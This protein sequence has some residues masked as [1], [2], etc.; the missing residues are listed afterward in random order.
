[1]LPTF[2]G[3]SSL[4]TGQI[5]TTIIGFTVIY[6]ALAVV[7]IGLMVRTIRRGPYAHHEDPDQADAVAP[8]ASPA[9]EGAH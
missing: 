5:W 8:G 7:E 6:S 4:T 2:L 1:V 3:T 9:A